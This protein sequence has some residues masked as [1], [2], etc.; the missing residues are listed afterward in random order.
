[1]FKF[2]KMTLVFITASVAVLQ[3]AFLARA[4]ETSSEFRQ[5]QTLLEAKKWDDAD[6]ETVSLLRNNPTSCPNLRAIDQ[7]WMQHSNNKYGFTPQL[8]IWQQTGKGLNCQTC[9]EEIKEFSKKV[10]WKLD[11]RETPLLGDFPAQYP[12]VAAL[13]WQSYVGRDTSFFGDRRNTWQASKV[14]GYNL[15]STFANCGK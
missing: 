9:E 7:L 1:M 15:F 5:L 14:Q 6:R 8:E 3:P 4:Q 12:T 13:G 10:G 2:G 11:S